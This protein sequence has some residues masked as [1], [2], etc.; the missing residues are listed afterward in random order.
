MACL[1]R[2]G[3]VFH[4]HRPERRF[5]IDE[6]QVQRRGGAGAE[7]LPDQVQKRADA[8][9]GAEEPRH[10]EIAARGAGGRTEQRDKRRMVIGQPG[11]GRTMA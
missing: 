6:G 2:G 1:P 11:R 8:I 7:D 4:G 10:L 5:G 3:G 9:L